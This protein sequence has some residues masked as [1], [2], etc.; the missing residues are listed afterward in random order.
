MNF[1]LTNDDGIDA[2]GLWAASRALAE[3]GRVLIVAPNANY[4]GYGAALPPSRDVFCEAYPAS[5]VTMP[6]ITAFSLAAP[7]AVCAQVG[8]SGA[9]SKMPIDL[10][11]S[12]INHGA[13]LGRDVLYS[14]T[15]GA[16]LTA[17]LLGKP[18]IAI[19]LDARSGGGGHW[20]TAAWCLKEIIKSHATG[21]AAEQPLLNANIPNRPIGQL[22]GI[23]ITSLGAT[24]CLD[25]YTISMSHEHAVHF[26]Q[27]LMP[28]TLDDPGSD[29]W[30]LANG[31]VSLTPLR[32]FPDIMYVS[33]AQGCFD[34]LQLASAF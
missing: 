20:N 7:P 25:R 24:S 29:A 18:A 17:H 21:S 9:L 2:P 22:T 14:G 23:E 16:A 28:T 11:V 1:L 27:G 8:L 10:V 12:G 30:A 4:S 33:S 31:S 34:R 6:G 13:N 3:L 5:G 15:V 26:E 19:S 32:L